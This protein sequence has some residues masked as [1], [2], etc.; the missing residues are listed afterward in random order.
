MPRK[1]KHLYGFGCGKPSFANVTQETMLTDLVNESSWF[2]VNLLRLTMT[3]FAKDVD[4]WEN[5]DHFKASKLILD[6]LNVVND[7]AERAVKLTTDFVSSARG[8]D[9][10]QNLI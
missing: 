1:L 7:P 5:N 2:T 8:E 3:F 4:S 10:F 9:H 6:G